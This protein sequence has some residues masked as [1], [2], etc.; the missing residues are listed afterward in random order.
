MQNL[1][2]APHD[3]AFGATGG[4]CGI[5][6]C[7]GGAH[8]VGIVGRQLA[9]GEHDGG[10]GMGAHPGTGEQEGAIGCGNEIPGGGAIPVIGGRQ[11]V[12]GGGHPIGIC[13]VQS[14]GGAQPTGGIGSHCG[15]G[16]HSGG[17]W[18]GGGVG[19][20]DPSLT[21]GIKPRPRNTNHVLLMLFVNI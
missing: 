7:G 15:V 2:Q 5:H 18:F 1:L 21:G 20:L 9:G 17:G 11:P 16:W 12:G 14:A 13:G 4:G 6:P 10:G 3:G 8:P 19:G